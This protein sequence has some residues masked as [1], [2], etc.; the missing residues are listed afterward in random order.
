MNKPDVIAETVFC[1]VERFKHTDGNWYAQKYFAPKV[2]YFTADEVDKFKKRFAREVKVQKNLDD[3]MFIPI[4]NANLESDPPWFVMPLAE[5]TMTHH[6]PAMRADPKELMSALGQ[7]LDALQHLHSL[8]YV[9]RDLK[10]PNILFQGGRWKLS[11]FGL[12]L[13]TTSESTK[14]TSSQSAWGTSAYCAPE[15]A[16][17]F[18]KVTAATD[19]YAFGCMLHDIFGVGQRIPYHRQTAPGPIGA[20]IERCTELNPSKRFKSLHGLRAALFDVLA[21]HPQG[22]AGTPSNAQASHFAAKLAVPESMSPK[23]I[24]DL[25]SFLRSISS[26]SEATEIF[27]ALNDERIDVLFGRDPEAWHELVT[28]YCEWVNEEYFDFNYCDVIVQRLSRIFFHG[29]IDIKALSMLAGA[30][31]GESHNRYYVMDRVLTLCGPS[32]PDDVA[33]RIAIEILASEMQPQFR[34]CATVIDRE[35]TAYHPRVA[36]VLPPPPPPPTP[37]PPPPLP[38]NF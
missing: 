23:D 5:K 12:V 6:V 13:P 17:E 26:P 2:G 34:A 24:S 4:V 37:P 18:G 14:L 15:Q 16:V 25:V 10:P 9:H 3:S 30:R 8:G 1:R 32:L 33:H 35:V 31:L 19:I 7:V 29:P 20:V 38:D 21:T 36:A 22:V 11:D 28:K 27:K